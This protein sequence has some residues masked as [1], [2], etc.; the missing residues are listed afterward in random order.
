MPDKSKTERYDGLAAQ[1]LRRSKSFYLSTRRSSETIRAYIVNPISKIVGAL[2]AVAHHPVNR[3]RSFKA[4]IEYGFIQVAARLV[5]G[6]VCVEFPNQ[7]RLLICPQMKGAAHYITPRLCEFEEMAFVMH[8]LRPNDVFVDVGAN[9]GA[10]TVMAAGVAGSQ[11]VAFEASPDTYQM[12]A[13]NIRLN[14]FGERVRAI[15]AAAGRAEGTAQFSQGLGTE[16]HIASAGGGELS[17]A[18]RMTTL[19]IELA[20][21]APR[22][23][24]VDVE[25]FETEVFAGAFAVL[26]NPALQCIIVERNEMGSRYGFDEERLHQEIRACGFVPCEYHP[27]DRELK[28]ISDTACRNIIYTRDLNAANV[29]LRAAPA[30]TLGDLSV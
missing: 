11:V 10:F 8:F 24:K 21:I 2:S 18:V 30:F 25:G 15:Q 5:P 23:L 27:F 19:D 7:L 17:T 22:L 20:G 13:R 3:R 29:V 26:R 14:G 9:I 6:D 12:L 28:P 1:N 16:N 4:V